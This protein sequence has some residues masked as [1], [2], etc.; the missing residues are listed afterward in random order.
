MADPVGAGHELNRGSSKAAFCLALELPL[1]SLT[2]QQRP[3]T[4]KTTGRLLFRKPTAA[5]R[6]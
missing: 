1:T 6:C 4:R 3:W 5:L 2:Q